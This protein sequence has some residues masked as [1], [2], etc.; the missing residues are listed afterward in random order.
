[1]DENTILTKG[2]DKKRR[3]WEIDFLRGF[4]ML[5]VM[6]DHLMYDIWALFASEITTSWGKAVAAFAKSYWTSGIRTATHHWFV[7]VFVV[8]SGL[9][10]VFSKNDLLKALKVAAAA[11][12]ITVVT[13]IAQD[14]MGSRTQILFGILH[15]LA[16]CGLICWLL[17]KLK[18]PDWGVFV[19][20]VTSLVV[21]YY[22]QSQHLTLPPNDWMM[23]LVDNLRGYAVSSDFFPLLPWLGWFLLGYLAGKFLYKDKST[24]IPCIN[25]KYVS[26]IT[27]VG[28]HSLIFYLAS[29]AVGIVLLG[30]LVL[31]GLI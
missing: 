1:M 12:L 15:M 29:Q 7:G 3:V 9:S 5:F 2:T 26:P 31:V 27:F 6:W 14:V 25:E 11:L 4:C 28:R 13:L 23:F 30:F 16:S 18:T 24:K 17:K 19:V 21:G 10:I 8:V 22:F 20:A